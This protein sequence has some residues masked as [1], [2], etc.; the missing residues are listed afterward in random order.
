MVANQLHSSKQFYKGLI[1]K[2]IAW[3]EFFLVKKKK[4]TKLNILGQTSL[5]CRNR[6]SH[7]FVLS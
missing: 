5:Y 6:F 3:K 7:L 2:D 4:K 1:S